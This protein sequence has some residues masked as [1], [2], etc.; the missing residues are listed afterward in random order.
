MGGI[1]TTSIFQDFYIEVIDSPLAVK[2][3]Q[4]FTGG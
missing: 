1:E 4:V 2:D 3:P